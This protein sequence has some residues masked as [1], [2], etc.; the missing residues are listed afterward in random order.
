M[1]NIRLL[2][3]YDGSA[4]HGW[5]E[6]PNGITIQGLIE[7]GL[8]EITGS[9]VDIIGA[10]RTDAGVHALGQC[11]CF[12]TSTGLAPETLKK[13]L[14]AKLP[15]DIRIIAAEEVDDSF[16]ARFS[17]TGKSYVYI[18]QTG[19]VTS[20]FLHKYLWSLPYSPD[21]RAMRDAAT[22]LLGAHDFSAFRGSGC[23]ARTTV[24]TI[25]SASIEEK[26][27]MEF[28]S[29]GMAGKFIVFRFEGNAFL[30]HMVRNMVGTLVDVG[31]RKTEPEAI[32]EILAKC[33]RRLAGPTAPAQ[34][35][36]L[37]RIYYD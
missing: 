14:N 21:I 18:L 4:Y 3:Q 34:G 30:R 6:Q 8:E 2:L 1:R 20:P 19:R 33:D 22:H 26:E 29:M 5:Q 37:E 35:L 28:M 17:A 11:A 31:R 32:A 16:H 9:E 10:G 13:A 23:G 15:P 12:R 7:A 24:R 36:F 27:G 25:R